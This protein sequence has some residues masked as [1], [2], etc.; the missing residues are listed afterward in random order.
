MIATYLSQKNICA[1][2]GLLM[3]FT[4]VWKAKTEASSYTQ[5]HTARFENTKP[6]NTIGQKVDV[7]HI[8]TEKLKPE[9]Q[10]E[11]LDFRPVKS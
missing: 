8:S 4:I 10:F 7:Y 3:A 1:V 2:L 5:E 11:D 6:T 9:I